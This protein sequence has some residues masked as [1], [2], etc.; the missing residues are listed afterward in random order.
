VP[1][2]VAS[3][4][5]L[6]CG[7]PTRVAVVASVQGSQI[8]QATLAHWV[9]ITQAEQ[10][11]AASPARQSAVQVQQSAL[12]FLITA[13]WLEG[14]AAA[15]GISVSAAQVS[16]TYQQLL[17]GL[18]GNS[19]ANTLRQRGMSAADEQFQ[20]RLS[21]LSVK[22]RTKIESAVSGASP[23][24]VAQYFHTHSAQFRGQTLER[25]RATI[26]Q[27]LLEDARRQRLDAFTSAFRARWKQRT[28]C[29]AGYVIAECRNSPALPASPA[30]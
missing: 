25:A 15:E 23:A 26:G 29:F 17:S 16:A 30:S 28:A 21:Q 3:L 6:A 10:Q 20:L 5:L 7:S 27:T 19:F 18:A 2:L 13:K 22:L 9:R 11:S 1:A 24:Q 14:E 4:L 12:A 8:S